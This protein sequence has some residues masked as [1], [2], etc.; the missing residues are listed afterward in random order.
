MMP[1]RR[2]QPRTKKIATWKKLL[3]IDEHRKGKYQMTDGEREEL[4][5][6]NAGQKKYTHH[7]VIQ[8][9]LRSVTVLDFSMMMSKLINMKGA[10]PCMLQLPSKLCGG[11]GNQEPLNKPYSL[12]RCKGKRNSRNSSSICPS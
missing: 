1:E 6:D 4:I 9:D 3:E 11:L 5:S 2:G 8:R 10:K 7:N 12:C